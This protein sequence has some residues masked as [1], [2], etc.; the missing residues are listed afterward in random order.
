MNL[1]E[2][3]FMII[4]FNE[5]IQNTEHYFVGKCVKC[6]RIYQSPGVRIRAILLSTPVGIFKVPVRRWIGEKR[7][8]YEH[9]VNVIFALRRLKLY[10]SSCGVEFFCNKKQQATSITVWRSGIKYTMYEFRRRV[11]RN[12]SNEPS[13]ASFFIWVLK[14]FL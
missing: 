13:Q 2:V 12:S 3:Y 9:N 5:Q 4:L 1:H 10:N 11:T 7:I 6:L 14:S 8:I